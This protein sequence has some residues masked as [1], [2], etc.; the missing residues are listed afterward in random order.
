MLAV[1]EIL[2]KVAA[3]VELAKLAIMMVK[4]QVE[5]VLNIVFQ[6]LP[7]TMQVEDHSVVLQVA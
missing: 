5:M 3:A 2:A 4:A 6:E 1:L 7:H